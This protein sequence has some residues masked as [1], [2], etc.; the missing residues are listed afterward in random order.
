MKNQFPEY[1]WIAWWYNGERYEDAQVDFVGAYSTP[2]LALAQ[3]KKYE[4]KHGY[5]PNTK[6]TIEKVKIDRKVIK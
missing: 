4:K 6:I 3:A 1:V 5:N 2:E